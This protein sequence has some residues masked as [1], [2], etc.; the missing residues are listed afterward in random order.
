MSKSSQNPIPA[1][2]VVA[3]RRH[4]HINNAILNAPVLEYL[5]EQNTAIYIYTWV[6]RVKENLACYICPRQ[7]GV[8]VD[9]REQ[10]SV[11][12]NWRCYV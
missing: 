2:V 5:T 8:V 4:I 7:A 11:L 10:S 1:V 6:A 9:V 3:V 12:L